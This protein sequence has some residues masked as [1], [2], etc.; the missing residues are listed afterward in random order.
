MRARFYK[1]TRG[2]TCN[3]FKVDNNSLG[4]IGNLQYVHV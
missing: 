1:T 2:A 4:L 3:L